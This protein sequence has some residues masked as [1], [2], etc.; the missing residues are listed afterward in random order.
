M[1][2]TPALELKSLHKSFG[3]TDI[4]HNLSL[5]VMP[6]ERVAI[7]GPNGAG[8]STLFDLISGRFAPSCGQVWLGGQRIDGKK[9]F[10]INRLGLARSFQISQLFPTLSVFE[11]LHCAMLWQQGLGY[12]AFKSLARLTSTN[13]RTRALMQRLQLES[14]CETPAKELS[15][16]Q[17]R[18]LELG[19][20]LA[21]D[22]A[23]LLLDEP[24]AGM[25]R[26]ET[27]HFLAL[28]GE[29]T[30]GKTLLIVEHDMS[31]VFG[32]ASKIAVIVQGELL[33]FDT[34]EAV[35]ANPLV[36]QAY[37]G[38]VLPGPALGA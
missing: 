38:A 15:Y 30:Q 21:S 2:R 24:T 14:A 36:Q 23:V 11:N 35:R 34:P 18:A 20:A 5:S 16:A 19:L 22:P 7:I 1:T 29:L 27:S 8:K 3:Q 12:S 9:P 10:E 32:L 28:I 17:Q 25:S 26:S 6:G 4:I 13:Q 33:A 37:L 31:V